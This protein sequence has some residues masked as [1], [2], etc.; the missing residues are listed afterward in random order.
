MEVNLKRLM[1]LACAAL[2]LDVNAVGVKC[3]SEKVSLSVVQE[4]KEYNSWPMIRAVGDR[5]V[6]TYGRGSGHTV[7]GAR[8]AYARTSTDCGLTWSPEVC[9]VNDP[10]VC[11]GVEGIGRDST[12]AVLCWMNCRLRR[13]GHIL[14]DLYRTRDGVAYEKIA[15]PDLSPEPIQITGIFSVPGVGLM[16][17]WFSGNYRSAEPCNSWGTLVSKDD[18]RTWVQRTVESGLPKSE[19]P[20]EQSAVHLGG[21]RILVI[22]RAESGAKRQFQLT[23]LD[24]GATWRKAGTNIRDV[25]ES[26]PSL[27]YDSKNGLVAN[28][29][30]HRGARKL[31]RRVV[32]AGFIFDRP[33]DWPPPEVLAEGSETRA[34][35]A[36]NVNVMEYRGR[37]LATFYSGTERDCAVYVVSIPVPSAAATAAAALEAESFYTLAFRASRIAHST[38]FAFARFWRHASRNA[39]E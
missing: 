39:S 30:Y 11:E 7:E 37:H 17:L 27:V 6:C 35:D 34:C 21:G 18:G 26:T 25:Q 4:A 10:G 36:G 13:K 2:V 12:G 33:N 14:H 1:L 8:G 32:D 9:I 20:T 24:G 31:K 38:A 19:W 15:A 22:G 29:Y 23:S 16:S 3:V 5:I 28:Y